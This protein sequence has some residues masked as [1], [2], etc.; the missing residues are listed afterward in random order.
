MNLEQS[1][2]Y[3]PSITQ[4][5]FNYT[6]QTSQLIKQ[7]HKAKQ[8]VDNPIYF[9]DFKK[10][11]LHTLAFTNNKSRTQ[12]HG[13]SVSTK[14]HPGLLSI[15]GNAQV[16]LLSDG[17][18]SGLIKRSKLSAGSKH[19]AVLCNCGVAPE[20]FDRA[21]DAVDGDG[22]VGIGAGLVVGEL[23]GGGGLPATGAGVG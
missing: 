8:R 2:N 19:K 16:W 13:V 6:R 14:R 7:M 11:A 3:V 22:D 20:L 4:R 1:Q 23:D 21:L 18:Y 9:S 15:Q 10:P 5:R 12:V 17:A